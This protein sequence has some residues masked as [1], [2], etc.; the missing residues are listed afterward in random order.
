MKLVVLGSGAVL[1]KTRACSGFLV[2]SGKAKLIVDL[3]SGAFLNLKKASDMMEIS[4]VL[5]THYHPDHTSDL[6]TFLEYK[7]VMQKS[8]GSKSL[9]QL[10][11]LGPKGL[12]DFLA[13][14]NETF[15]L[16]KEASFKI[17]TKELENSFVMVPGFRVKSMQMNHDN[18]IAYRVEAE[19]K[20]FVFSG[21][22]AYTENLVSLAHK[23]NLLVAD[24]S[25]PDNRPSSSHMTPLQCAA[26]AKE[27]DVESL[28]LTHFYP[29]IESEPL[30]KIVSSVYKGKIYVANDLMKLEI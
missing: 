28:L 4:N 15:P 9:P 3:G 13:K 30:E 26:I 18:A 11:V 5:L 10:N 1:S 27:A 23:A 24:C 6:A 17:I 2:E 12:N 7:I 29:E 25:F 8:L 20:S 21:D 19:G 16:L 14:L 22:T